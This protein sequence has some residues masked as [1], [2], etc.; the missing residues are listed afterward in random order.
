MIWQIELKVLL[1]S[2][3]NQLGQTKI[4]S[5][6]DIDKVELNKSFYPNWNDNQLLKLR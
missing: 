5:V 6:Y 2:T 4:L 3:K 1:L